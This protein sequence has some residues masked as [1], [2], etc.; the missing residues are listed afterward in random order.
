MMRRTVLAIVV[1][2]SFSPGPSAASAQRVVADTTQQTLG[3]ATQLVVVTTA[4]WEATTGE[5][6]RFV[7]DDL[8]SSWRRE[9]NV[10]PVVIGRAGLAWGAG[11]D[12]LADAALPTAGPRKREGDGRSPAGVFP[13]GDAFGFAAADSM[14]WVRLPYLPLTATSECV[15]DTMSVHYNT[16]VDRHAVPQ[17]DWSSAEQMLEIEVYRLGVIVGYNAAPRLRARGSCIFLHI[18]GGPGSTTSGCTA[19]DEDELAGLMAWLDPQARPAVVQVP[20]AMYTRLRSE[21]GLPAL[22]G[23]AR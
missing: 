17:V 8:G 6:R 10:V 9:G 11:F 12:E 19:L 15:D 3:D 5:L 4:D 2:W 20:A 7:R 22:D 1:A 23:T 18:W 16:V 13:L 14:R 21:W